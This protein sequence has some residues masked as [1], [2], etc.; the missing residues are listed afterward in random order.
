[1]NKI[2]IPAATDDR[3]PEQAARAAPVALPA[4]S[5]KVSELSKKL[6]ESALAK[7]DGKRGAMREE[8]V[9]KAN[10]TPLPEGSNG[11]TPGYKRVEVKDEQAGVT[12]RRVVFDEKK[13][14]EAEEAQ[15]SAPPAPPPPSPPA[16]G[17]SA[18]TNSKK[19]E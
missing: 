8:L 18:D 13:R 14:E 12:E 19:G 9:A 15:A 17:S 3:T 2:T 10:K 1:M 11:L 6:D 16:Q 4:G 7:N 5:Y